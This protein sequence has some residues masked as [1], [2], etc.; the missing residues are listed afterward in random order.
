MVDKTLI[1]ITYRGYKI[2]Y[3]EN[4]EM[5]ECVVKDEKYP[6]K[7]RNLRT[8]K[9][10]IDRTFRKA[11]KP[12]PV[13]FHPTNERGWGYDETRI[14][15]GHIVQIGV[16]GRYFVRLQGGTKT[17]KHTGSGFYVDSAA[18]R[19]RIQK[20]IALDAK[21]KKLERQSKQIEWRLTEVDTEKLKE[22]VIGKQ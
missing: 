13:F 14:V 11:F 15:R 8:L 9:A 19:K 10:A 16:D 20:K 12:I 17:L 21:I 3:N 7:E 5:W 1:T 4:E 2:S 6:H 22:R 18:N